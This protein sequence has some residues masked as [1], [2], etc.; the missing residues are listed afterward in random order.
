L[1]TRSSAVDLRER[2]YLSW[3]TPW[4]VGLPVHT[5]DIKTWFLYHRTRGA[6]PRM[7]REAQRR[8]EGKKERE[9]RKKE[10]H[11]P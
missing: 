3:L 8:G 10:D 6:V 4:L 11:V 7:I 1:P 2:W 9:S 5:L